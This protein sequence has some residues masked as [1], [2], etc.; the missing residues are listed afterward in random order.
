[1]KNWWWEGN[2]DKFS[3]LAV[4]QVPGASDLGNP[5]NVLTASKG[6]SADVQAKIKAAAI[7]SKDV[8]GGKEMA[9]FDGSA[10][11]F[12]LGL[13]SKGKIDPMTYSW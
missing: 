1:M 7:K 13:M 10:L 4:Y 3:S 11:D 8:F 2:K 5:D 12:S 6:V 9:E